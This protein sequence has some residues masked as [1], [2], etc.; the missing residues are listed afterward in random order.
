MDQI[1][2]AK[3]P[4]LIHS[5]SISLSQLTRWIWYADSITGPILLQDLAWL[6]FRDYSATFAYHM[7]SSGLPTH[8][9]SFFRTYRC[10]FLYNGHFGWMVRCKITNSVKMKHVQL[11]CIFTSY[12]PNISF[13]PYLIDNRTAVMTCAY[14]MS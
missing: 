3:T 11:Q 7:G 4:I 2:R 12:N 10:L 9:G 1:G 5:R 8:A 13:F 14:V 6:S